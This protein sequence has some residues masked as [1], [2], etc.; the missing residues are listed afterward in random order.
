MSTQLSE[1]IVLNDCAD[2]K[3]QW[4]ARYS[5]AVGALSRAGSL[6]L[7]AHTCRHPESRRTSFFWLNKSVETPGAL[8]HL[9]NRGGDSVLCVWGGRWFTSSQAHAS[10]HTQRF[11]LLAFFWC[12]AKKKWLSTRKSLPHSCLKLQNPD[13][14]R[15]IMIIVMDRNSKNEVIFTIW[16]VLGMRMLTEHPRLYLTCHLVGRMSKLLIKLNT[17]GKRYD[18]NTRAWHILDC[19]HIL[20]HLSL[21]K[22]FKV[23]F[24]WIHWTKRE[25]TDFICLWSPSNGCGWWSFPCC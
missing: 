5:G 22:F 2:T 1:V 17:E 24:N 15:R 3:Q 6:P 14:L 10:A 7:P 4:F 21:S 9:W 19:P 11:H 25:L 13:Y 18:C 12:C 16:N 8:L 20:R 23:G